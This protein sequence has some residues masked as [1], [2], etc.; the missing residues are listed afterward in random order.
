M[1]VQD[2]YILKR[3]SLGVLINLLGFACPSKKKKKTQF[4]LLLYRTY[5]FCEE[6]VT[7]YFV[8]KILFK[9]FLFK[10]F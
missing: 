10:T 2:N 3:R 8:C 7:K 6:Q 1:K 9:D 5:F 4:L